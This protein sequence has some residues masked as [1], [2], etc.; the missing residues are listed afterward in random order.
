MG[1]LPAGRQPGRERGREVGTG[2]P[3]RTEG[4]GPT[5]ITTSISAQSTAPGTG[6]TSTIRIAPTQHRSPARLGA[7]DLIT[8]E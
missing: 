4:A 6:A 1:E 8:L 7:V 5:A 3:D 2:Q